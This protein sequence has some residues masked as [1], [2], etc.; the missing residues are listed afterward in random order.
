VDDIKM[1]L[2][3]IGWVGVDWI[4]LALDKDQGMV[5]VNTILTFGLYQ[6]LGNS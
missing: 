3:D 4:D 6:I 5:L 2:R 1:D